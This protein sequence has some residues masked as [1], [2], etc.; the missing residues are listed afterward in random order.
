M[1]Q[2][3]EQRRCFHHHAISLLTHADSAFTNLAISGNNRN[4]ACTLSG[5][6]GS[7]LF[8]CPASFRTVRICP[9]RAVQ[10]IRYGGA[11]PTSLPPSASPTEPSAPSMLDEQE[12]QSVSGLATYRAEFSTF[13]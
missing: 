10:S 7:T 5:R 4:D 12:M 9:A 3:A 8:G 6:T 1:Q 2:P 11:F 13:S